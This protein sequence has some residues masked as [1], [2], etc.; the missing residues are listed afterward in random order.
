MT[1]T[2]KHKEPK[3]SYS[4]P[5]SPREIWIEGVHYHRNGIGGEGFKVIH[6]KNEN[7]RDLI[8]IV[9][10]AHDEDGNED[11]MQ[12]RSNIKVI[13]PMDIR[14]CYRGADFYGEILLEVSE[15]DGW[16]LSRFA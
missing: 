9:T 10:V 6:F 15:D 14:D 13:N 3:Y 12:T 5:G 2:N 1:A 11:R 8:G 7:G 16:L 4:L